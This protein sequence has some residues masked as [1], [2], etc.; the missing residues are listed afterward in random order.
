MSS[1][2]HYSILEIIRL[3]ENTKIV[4]FPIAL[5]LTLVLLNNEL[6]FIIVFYLLIIVDLQ[7]DQISAAI[8][9]L[10]I[11]LFLA[12]G[13]V[14]S[15]QVGSSNYARHFSTVKFSL[16]KINFQVRCISLLLPLRLGSH[17]GRSV[18]IGFI[19]VHI[20][21]GP[22]ANILNN[23]KECVRVIVCQMST[24]FSLLSTKYDIMFK[25]LR[26]AFLQAR[27]IE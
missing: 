16:Y 20:A 7:L 24:T 25:P 2:N 1:S 11:C 14:V 19:I 3:I 27:V 23:L 6:H 17:T 5:F 18:L 26:Q 21:A 13:N 8:L 12:I 9:G 10:I 22:L 4:T 15:R